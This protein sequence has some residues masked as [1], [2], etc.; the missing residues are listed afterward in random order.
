MLL[1]ESVQRPMWSY[2]HTTSASMKAVTGE[3]WPG[4]TDPRVY[5]RHDPISGGTKKTITFVKGIRDAVEEVFEFRSSEKV[6]MPVDNGQWQFASS[7]QAKD[8]YLMR[9]K[10]LRQGFLAVL[11]KGTGSNSTAIGRLPD[12]QPVT[13]PQLFGAARAI[14]DG[15]EM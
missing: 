11:E 4:D 6:R 9:A 13:G 7:T 10:D 14:L 12:L 5:D 8:A 3:G 2:I 15:I 1:E